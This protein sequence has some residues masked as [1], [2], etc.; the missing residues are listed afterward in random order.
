MK[1]D[2]KLVLLLSAVFFVILAVL[3]GIFIKSNQKPQSFECTNY[4][5]GTYVQQT[6]YGKNAQQ[7]AKAAAQKIGE[8]EN[9]ISWRLGDSDISKLDFDRSKNGGNPSKKP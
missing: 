6:V 4:A 2:K 1:K 8:L 3:A 9:L 7:A 5:M